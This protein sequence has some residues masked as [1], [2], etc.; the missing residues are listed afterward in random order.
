MVNP[1]RESKSAKSY[2]EV[3]K[4]C[5]EL[6]SGDQMATPIARA[7]NE[8]RYGVAEVSKEVKEVA[9]LV[10]VVQDRPE[11]G[12]TK[13]VIGTVG[14]S[15]ELVVMLPGCSFRMLQSVEAITEMLSCITKVPR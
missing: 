9:T 10:I 5:Q 4:F 14:S 3:S 11:S 8:S 7:M 13:C 15:N 1:C 2:I 12:E 6:Y